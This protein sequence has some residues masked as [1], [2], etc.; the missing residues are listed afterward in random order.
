MTR[1]SHLPERCT[2]PSSGTLRS[3]SRQTLS[4]AS[5]ILIVL[6]S[7]LASLHAHASPTARTPPP[8]P[9]IAQHETQPERSQDT[10]HPSQSRL[11]AIQD[12]VNE[13]SPN[14]P[15][16]HSPHE[17]TPTPSF[18]THPKFA[19]V[20]IQVHFQ[21]PVAPT[22]LAAHNLYL[23]P[24]T[25]KPSSLQVWDF[26]TGKMAY[27]LLWMNDDVGVGSGS[28]NMHR[29]EWYGK[30]H[31]LFWS[32]KFMRWPGYGEGYYVLLDES[33]N[34]VFNVTLP[35]PV[36][37]HDAKLTPEHTLIST[38]W[39]KLGPFDHAAYSGSAEDGS[40]YDAAF[41]EYSPLTRKPVFGWSPYEAGLSLWLS[42][43]KGKKTFTTAKPWDWAH[44]NS[45]AKDRLGNYLVS[46]RSLAT[47]FYID[48]QTKE[49]LWQLGGPN[50]NF[51][52]DGNEFSW[53][54]NA[55][56]LE[57]EAELGLWKEDDIRAAASGKPVS[58]G[59]K[60]E[61]RNRHIT[62]YDNG[63]LSGRTK[64]RNES[65][66]LVIELDMAKM[67][68]KIVQIYE[69]PD[70]HMPPQIRKAISSSSQG[71][72]QVLAPFEAWS[73][74]V[75]GGGGD[76]EKNTGPAI[77]VGQTPVLLAYGMKPY[78]ALYDRQGDPLWFVEYLAPK[79]SLLYHGGAKVDSYRS[80][81][82]PRWRGKPRWPPRI[83]LAADQSKTATTPKN[84]GRQAWFS[85]NGA[86][87]VAEYRVLHGV[88][89]S[90]RVSIPREGFET[91]AELGRLI[92]GS[93]MIR[94]E[95]VD[96]CG[97]VLA[98]SPWLR[99]QGGE[100][101]LAPVREGEAWEYGWGEE[102]DRCPLP[103]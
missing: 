20:T 34:V 100:G 45:V 42:R 41:V 73:G 85:W 103:M 65:R 88:R 53:Q 55:L 71:N 40:I 19:P 25:I 5:L 44:T 12:D 83:K 39:R 92:M 84:F 98:K 21:S 4:L 80:Y 29:V 72:L 31:I 11:H 50:T 43:I 94:V 35:D 63:A 56:W 82:A 93:E 6:I 96:G 46:L 7:I 1:R 87:G 30:P 38:V 60:G 97:N 3:R 76:A 22:I 89:T 28:F 68:A 64:D 81:L 18:Q 14:P 95:A 62:L 36:D 24:V 79:T 16:W 8:P 75:G 102:T 78:L 33:Y 51:T 101:F 48:G 2:F 90:S 70:K 99:V 57:E 91:V 59:A 13:T 9:Q 17:P 67:E 23:A 77:G 52:G 69:K 10:N 74:D 58:L 15:A 47:L 49:I 66:G 37:F 27:E 61:I 54:H 26:N 86:S 32:G